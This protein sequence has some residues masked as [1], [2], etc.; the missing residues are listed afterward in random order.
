MNVRRLRWICEFSGL[1]LI[2]AVATLALTLF[3]SA[4]SI[5]FALIAP[6][7]L[8]LF[9]KAL[10][11][12]T[13][14]FIWLLRSLRWWHAFWL[15][16]F[17]S[18]LV[19]RIRSG[20]SLYEESL[21]SWAFFRVA[22]VSLTG[23]LLLGR[24]AV[25]RTLW[26]SSMVRGLIG[27]VTAYSL[28]CV[29]STLWSVYP[30]WTLYKSLEYL[31]DVAMLAAL[32]AT[33]RSREGYQNLFDWTWVLYGL[34][35]ASVWMGVL[36]WPSQ[37]LHPRIGALGVQLDGIF[38]AVN[39]NSVGEFA[40]VLAIVALTRLL[41]QGPHSDRAWYG[42]LFVASFITMLFAQ[43]RSA[44]AGFVVGA[45]LVLSF[46]KR[47]ILSIG[48]AAGAALFLFLAAA[49]G[50]LWE[51]LRRG[52]SDQEIQSLSGRTEYWQLAWQKFVEHPL[53]GYGAYAAGRSFI[54]TVM[55]ED[56]GSMHSEYVEILMGT[57]LWGMV[58]VVA[59]LLATWWWLI[60]SLRDSSLD[61]FEH[62]LAVEASGVLAVI[63]V[64]SFFS[65]N[66]FWHV[67][68]IFFAVLSYAEFLRRKKTSPAALPRRLPLSRI[69]CNHDSRQVSTS[70][71]L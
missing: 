50:W 7:L 37:A 52:E 8:V 66:L 70:S 17:V 2:G 22:L 21:D 25:R 53:I 33:F 38:P 64:R 48:L 54:M 63:S 49:N 59:A 41:R 69:S 24:L 4:L 47:A 13:R 26:V 28:I 68:L 3:H 44:I 45:I 71:G 14:K 16:L 1:V 6:L 56:P 12:G 60:R 43:G 65:P 61:R 55:R 67:P 20:N 32:L 57:G 34:L 11:D 9:S 29:A 39:A 15:L 46:S 19:F 35:L 23:L 27:I 42:L 36:I 18:G 30:A 5:L 40:A 58:P 10:L 31:V 51:F 62:S